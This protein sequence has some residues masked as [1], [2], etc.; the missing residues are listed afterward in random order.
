LK[1]NVSSLMYGVAVVVSWRDVATSRNVLFQIFRPTTTALS[2]FHRIGKSM[3]QD[4]ATETERDA[5]P[6]HTAD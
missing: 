1:N 6:E 5:R 3:G 4:I 2:V